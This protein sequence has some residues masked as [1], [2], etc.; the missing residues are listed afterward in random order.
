M[1]P[2]EEATVDHLRGQLE[3]R[4]KEI[5]RLE[6]QIEELIAYIEKQGWEKL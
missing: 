6:R 3:Q 5:G 2:K 1:T 4:N